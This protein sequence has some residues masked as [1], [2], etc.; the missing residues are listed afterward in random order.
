MKMHSYITVNGQLQF[1]AQ[2]SQSILEDLQEAAHLSGGWG[3]AI[4]LARTR[5]AEA[6][7]LAG[8]NSSSPLDSTPS[9]TPDAAEGSTTSYT[10]AATASAL[11][12]RLAA[13]SSATNGN[14]SVVDAS[15]SDSQLKNWENQSEASNE[16]HPPF[17]PHPLVDHPDPRIAEIAK[18]YSE[19]QSE[20]TSPGPCYVQWPN[21]ITLKN[22]AVYQLIP[23]LV[24]EL[25]YPRTD[26]YAF[27][28]LLIR[29]LFPLK[30]IAFGRS[31]SLRRRS[32]D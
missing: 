10:D 3:Q 32:V 25:E 11:R 6:D 1:A 15:I 14:L 16:D 28:I 13:V 27:C 30:K 29:P 26:R 5:R 22:F 23:T 17:A 7:A 19:L 9:R 8:M 24:Y 18:D 12:K 31:M 21:N 2:Q 4:R 20:L